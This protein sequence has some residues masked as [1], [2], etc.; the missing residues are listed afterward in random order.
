MA[1]RTA[2]LELY[3]YT[4]LTGSYASTDLKYTIEKEL[5]SGETKILFE[6]GELVRDFIT[7]NF[8][9][10]Y[11]SSTIW[12]T[13]YTTLFDD[14]NKAFTY[15]NPVIQSYLAF[16]GYGYFE[17]EINPQLSTNALIS[18]NNIYLPEDTAGKIPIFAEG[19]GK[20]IIDSTTTQITDNGNSNQKIQYIAIPANS[21]EIKVYDTDDS[22]LKK[23]I[24]VTNLCEPKYTPF[25][26]TFINKYGAYENL[27]FFKK[28][29]ESLNVT[30]ETFKRNTISNSA[31]TYATN[32]GQEQRYNINGITSLSLN[33]GFILED[34]NSTIE[35]LFLSEN[36]WIRYENKT[37]PVIPKTKTLQF[38]TILNDRLIN[39]TIDFEFAFNKINNVR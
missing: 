17:D 14:L 27:Y 2:V 29:T 20:I 19:V 37:Q 11:L 24:T 39:H 12:V 31:V 21:S 5:I 28:T 9:N 13:A 23:T 22:T 1:L 33:T 38:K 16:N 32:E 26:I 15:N 8:N 6:I 30:D 3:V 34:M 18:S 7:T 4:G 36:V 10:D 35:E 25:K